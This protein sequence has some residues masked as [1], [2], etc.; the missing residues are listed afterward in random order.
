VSLSAGDPVT[1][2]AS[3]TVP[4]GS[5]SA[6]FTISTRAV[7]GTI[8]AT[9]SGS[10][11]GASASAGLSVTKSTVAT[12]SFGVSGPTESE[13]CTLTNNGNTL[14][15]TFDGSTSGAPGT[16]IAWDWSYGVATTFAQTTSGP[17]LTMP[18][19]NCNLLPPPFPPGEPWFTMIVTL[20]VHDDLGNVSAVVT[21]NG[22]RL[23]PQGVC[24]F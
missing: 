18:S 24:G 2:P 19:V 21:D 11:G 1:V 3:V 4:A 17:V 13:T 10:Y 22:V 7:G 5:A 16:I 15:C 9:I 20:K 6:T 23:L 8:S 12:A 14:N